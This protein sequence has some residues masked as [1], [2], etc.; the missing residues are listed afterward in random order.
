M[1]RPFCRD[2]IAQRIDSLGCETLCNREANKHNEG[3]E[4]KVAVG[5]FVK[6]LPK[7]LGDLSAAGDSQRFEKVVGSNM[8]IVLTNFVVLS[9]DWGNGF[10]VH[11][12]PSF[13]SFPTCS[14]SKLRSRQNLKSCTSM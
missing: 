7:I 11:C 13:P 1:I 12:C 10:I 4:E 9:R 5:G 14:T 6:L 8:W 3:N 2:V